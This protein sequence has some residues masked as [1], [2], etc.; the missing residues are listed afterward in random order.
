MKFD[1]NKYEII[2][3]SEKEFFYS[4]EGDLL[5]KQVVEDNTRIMWRAQFYAADIIV[6]SYEDGTSVR[7]IDNDGDLFRFTRL[8]VSKENEDTYI[9]YEDDVFRVEDY[10]C[11]NDT[12]YTISE[13]DTKK[14]VKFLR[15]VIKP[16]LN[17]YNN[18]LPIHQIKKMCGLV[19]EIGDYFEKLF[20]KYGINVN[21]PEEE[22]DE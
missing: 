2:D 21:F 10:R 19:K 18:R 8:N 7:I 15:S 6:E 5:F 11:K 3:Y 9:I 4:P 13:E 20:D 12:K 17:Q 22:D 16:R 14:L 1:I